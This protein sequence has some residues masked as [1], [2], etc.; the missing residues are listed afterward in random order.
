MQQILEG[1]FGSSC[2]IATWLELFLL[3]LQDV[4]HT[5]NQIQNDV[6]TITEENRM[7][8]IPLISELAEKMIE[9]RSGKKKKKEMLADCLSFYN[10][11]KKAT[12]RG[13]TMANNMKWHN[14]QIF[15]M[16]FLKYLLNSGFPLQNNVRASPNDSVMVPSISCHWWNTT[17]VPLQ[18]LLSKFSSRRGWNDLSWD[19][20]NTI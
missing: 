6:R 13:P 9:K 17:V 7:I 19:L 1:I 20:K 8:K 18:I 14:V 4:S 11:I 15:A 16:F 10:I 2:R 3:W 12:E 5:I